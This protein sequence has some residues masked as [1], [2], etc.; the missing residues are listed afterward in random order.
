MSPTVPHA[1]ITSN[2][3]SSHVG[4]P[5]T[6]RDS[7][8]Q[9]L[10]EWDRL[11]FLYLTDLHIVLLFFYAYKLYTFWTKSWKS[12]YFVDFSQTYR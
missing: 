11:R 4:T 1:Q 3:S 7:L 9:T 2:M 12:R 8:G 5:G 6:V 10:P